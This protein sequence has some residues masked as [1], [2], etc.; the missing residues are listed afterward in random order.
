MA[1]DLIGKTPL[2][3]D[4]KP[5][6][7]LAGSFKKEPIAWVSIVLT[8][9]IFLSPLL[10]S[11]YY[12]IVGPSYNI[13]SE[14]RYPPGT[15]GDNTLLVR[16]ENYSDIPLSGL[17]VS[18]STNSNTEVYGS[19]SIL[20]GTVAPNSMSEVRTIGL[21]FH[22]PGSGFIRFQCS[23]INDESNVRPKVVTTPF[24]VGHPSILFS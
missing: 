14:F 12:W 17:K 22:Q 2:I 21:S 6:R 24:E 3:L 9:V 5:W 1:P 23:P 16:I 10:K 7:F 15:Q 13:L 11:F 18:V 4:S 19:G 8:V 20:F